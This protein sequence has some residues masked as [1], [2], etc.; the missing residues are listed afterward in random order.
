MR[1]VSVVSNTRVVFHPK[2]AGAAGSNGTMSHWAG[3]READNKRMYT[4]THK[5]ADG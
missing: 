2:S 5:A 4:Y 3:K 1:R